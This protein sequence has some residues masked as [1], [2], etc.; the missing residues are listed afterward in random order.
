MSVLLSEGWI[1]IIKRI[2]PVVWQQGLKLYMMI[3][4][5]RNS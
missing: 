4:R 2:R 5:N 3:V 1:V